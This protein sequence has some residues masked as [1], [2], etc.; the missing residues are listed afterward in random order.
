MSIYSSPI[1]VFNAALIRCGEDTITAND[2]GLDANLFRGAYEPFVRSQLRKHRW[3]FATKT[4]LLVYQGTSGNKPAYVYQP[5]SEVM[6]VHK[7]TIESVNWTEYEL[8]GGKLLTDVKSDDI[9]LHYTFR[10]PEPDWFD[11]FAEGIVQHMQSLI[12]AALGESQRSKEL[13]DEASVTLLDALGR[14]AN[15]QQKERRTGRMPLVDAWRGVGR[16]A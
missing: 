7:C 11:D 14:D 15:S 1:E 12:Y 4:E 2:E 3:S 16:R 5:T 6:L 13:R 9:H 8:R 10:A